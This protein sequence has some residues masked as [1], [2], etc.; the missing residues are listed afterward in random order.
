MA[1]QLLSSFGK[2]GDSSYTTTGVAQ[3]LDQIQVDIE[4]T[5][6]LSRYFQVV[7]FDPA[8]TAGKNCISFNGSDLLKDGSE[9]KIEVLDNDG[10]SLYLVSTPKGTNYVDIANFTVSIYIFKE[11]KDG[12][13][14][15]FLVGTT[16]KGE[17]VRWTGNISINTKFPNVSRVRF[18]NPKST[19]SEPYME[20]R[21]LL[22]PVIE[23]LTGSTL[24]QDVTVSGSFFLRVDNSNGFFT[25]GSA[26]F[27]FVLPANA[28]I[29][30]WSALPSDPN[31]RVDSFNAQM[32]GSPIQLHYDY[33]TA[34]ISNN[35]L[36]YQYKHADVSAIITS[37]RSTS[38]IIVD[39]IPLGP[40]AQLASSG[41]FTCSF[42]STEYIMQAVTQPMFAPLIKHT[43]TDPGYMEIH[44]GVNTFTSSN[45]GQTVTLKYS[46]LSLSGSS[47]AAFNPAVHTTFNQVPVTGSMF[48]VLDVTGSQIIHTPSFLYTVYEN[49][50]HGIV[51][52]NY[53]ASK[54]TGSITVLS[55]SNPYQGYVNSAGSAS[56]MKKSYAGIV[57]RNLGTFTG[58]VARHKLYAKSNIYPGNF[59]LIDDTVLGPSEL[60][61]DPITVN[62]NF[63]TIGTFT[64]QDQINQYWFASS[65]SLNLIYSDKPRLSSMVIHP[66]NGYSGSDGNS[67]V[68]VKAQAIGTTNDYN[69]YP[70][71]AAAYNQFS[72]VGYTSNFIFLA[73]NTTYILQSDMIVNKNK[74]ETAKV[75]F[76]LTSSSD[77]IQNET[78]YMP[79]FGWKLGEI[80]VTDTVSSRIFSD[81]QQLFFTPLNDYYGTL[82]I[83]PVNCEV[84]LGNISLKNYGDYGFSP[85]SAVVQIPFP[86]NIANESWTIK[87]EL[88]DANYNLIY[89][90]APVVQAFDPTGASL[91]GNSIIGTGTS[92]GGN[93]T[94]TSLTLTNNLFLPNITEAITPH[95]FLGYNIP[96]HHPPLSGEGSLGY[97]EVEDISLIPTNGTVT[98]KD[99]ISVT[100]VES[101]IEHNGR[102]IAVRYSG[103]AP[104]VY[105]RRVYV[106][107]TGTKHTYS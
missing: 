3:G 80:V 38:E 99:Y 6:H 66:I 9:I 39:T 4:D 7:E 89:T 43:P 2:K 74:T 73:Q 77:T 65:A 14:K 67:Y 92:T 103:S 18:F 85:Q 70:Y 34:I 46:S 56:F 12:P 45:V 82:V 29:V 54:V 33:A 83:V 50:G 48:T 78:S 40:Y 35:P 11:T 15:I 27:G 44:V 84:I 17:V 10:N 53:T 25:P 101:G 71:D 64:N 24:T 32:V 57:Y 107:P 75:M 36:V 51:A 1:K 90:L 41:M 102:S 13:G 23:N 98:S 55:A 104:E 5:S 59:S 93:S 86:I 87:A 60:L 68:I 22:Y 96:T 88:F 62:K 49:H 100:T 16:A 72:G 94:L 28:Q 95:R 26:N 63:S 91:F 97:T 47:H 30:M 37:V 106:D 81:P 21:S 105:G 52:T 42:S 20:A 79:P 61:V 76:F 58:F 19:R 8:F 31:S 69:Y